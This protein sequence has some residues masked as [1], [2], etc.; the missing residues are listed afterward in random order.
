MPLNGATRMPA[1]GRVDKVNTQLSGRGG[2]ERP[3]LDPADRRAFVPCPEQCFFK[4][5]FRGGIE[6]LWREAGGY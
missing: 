5:E 4:Q 3:S 6:A 2:H 1:P